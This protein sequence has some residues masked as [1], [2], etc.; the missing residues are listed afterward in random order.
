MNK[1]RDF[2]PPEA[3][4]VMSVL[5]QKENGKKRESVHI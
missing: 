4:R 1:R 3:I 5:Y 2:L